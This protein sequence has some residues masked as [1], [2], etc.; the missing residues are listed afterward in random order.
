[1]AYS[2]YVRAEVIRRVGEGITRA[3]VA[4]ALEIPHQTIS[5]WCIAA[6]MPAVDD[7]PDGRAAD[8]LADLSRLM[9]KPFPEATPADARRWRHVLEAR[10]PRALPVPR[11]LQ[12][13]AAMCA[14]QGD[15][16]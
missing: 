4:R 2:D 3:E 1:M 7:D 15:G 8:H 14:A 16:A 5:E 12:S 9:R 10:I 13:P 11:S 6:G